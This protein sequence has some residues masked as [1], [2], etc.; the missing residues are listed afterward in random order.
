[1]SMTANEN[2]DVNEPNQILRVRDVLVK[3]TA[4]FKG[5]GLAS[6]RLDTELLIANALGWERIKLYTNYEYPL[7]PDE[8]AR[9][10]E[11]VR[12]RSLGEPVAYILG[13]KDFFGR[14]FQVDRTVLIPRPETEMLVEAVVNWARALSTPPLRIVDLG[15]GS[16]C[17]GLSL[18]CELADATLLAVDLSE[19]ALKIAEKNALT[20]SVAPRARFL[21][22]DAAAINYSH[23]TEMLG[24]AANV[25]VANPPY[26]AFDDTE[27]EKSVRDFEP[28]LALFA[29]ENGLGLIRAWAK[30]SLHLIAPGALVI[31]E[32]GYAQSSAVENILTALAPAAKVTTLK[33]LAGFDR[34]VSVDLTTPVK[35]AQNQPALDPADDTN[36][37]RI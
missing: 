37:E 20:L 3:T 16:G 1:M 12:R 32:I 33:D 11:F 36:D 34:F 21:C 25:V 13:K 4:F 29:E 7:S 2:R 6:P 27:V 23:V 10:R 17:I 24:G 9:C 19:A 35:L 30:N 18:L 28:H 8:L 15:T 26:I 5:K 22:A 31:F 14:S